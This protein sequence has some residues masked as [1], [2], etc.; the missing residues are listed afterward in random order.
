MEQAQVKKQSPE[1]ATTAA[2]FPSAEMPVIK[3]DL[4]GSEV[5]DDHS[6]TTYSIQL[7]S[8]RTIVQAQNAMTVFREKGLSAYWAE[9]DLGGNEK[10]FRVYTGF[11]ESREQAKRYKEKQ[12]LQKSLVKETPQNTHMETSKENPLP[13]DQNSTKVPG[14]KPLSGTTQDVKSSVPKVPKTKEELPLKTKPDKPSSGTKIP[15]PD[16]KDLGSKLTQNQGHDTAVTAPELKPTPIKPAKNTAVGQL[17]AEQAPAEKTQ[18]TKLNAKIS[19]DF[20]TPFFG[21]DNGADLKKYELQKTYPKYPYSIQL[22]SFR[23]LDGARKAVDSYREKGIPAYLSE[24]NRGGKKRWFRVYTGSFES[25]EQARKYREENNLLKSLVKETPYTA[26][27]G[28]YK[29]KKVLEDQTLLLKNLDYVPYAIEEQDGR[30]RLFIGA[31][32]DIKG[33]KEKQQDLESR[34]IQSQVIRR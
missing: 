19:A 13:E 31:F 7:G 14:R 6:K 8:F 4:K 3:P 12:N 17:P 16:S 24:V 27:V 26:F 25:R 22:G 23:T 28:T 5:E 10:W 34:G 11:F 1:P 29:D 9:V 15:E 33:A 21:M 2:A 32:L 18:G 20:F 30:Y